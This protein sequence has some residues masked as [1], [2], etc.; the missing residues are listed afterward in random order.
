MAI[1]ASG[2]R[3]CEALWCPHVGRKQASPLVFAIIVAAVGTIGGIL[4][5]DVEEAGEVAI[6]AAERFAS[7]LNRLACYLADIPADIPC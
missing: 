6:Q 2:T 3:Q 1:T 7:P 5:T 4:L